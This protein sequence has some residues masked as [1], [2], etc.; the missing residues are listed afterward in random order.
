[1]SE[2][3]GMPRRILGQKK[4]G[5]Y[6]I[7]PRDIVT[8]KVFDKVRH[9]PLRPEFDRTND[10]A[11]FK[12]FH[13]EF[14]GDHS[15]ISG[16]LCAPRRG[17]AYKRPA[18]L[19]CRKGE[20]PVSKCGLTDLHYNHSKINKTKLVSKPKKKPIEQVQKPRAKRDVP[21]KAPTSKMGKKS[22]GRKCFY[23]ENSSLCIDYN[24]LED[25]LSLLAY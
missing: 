5:V 8:P 15:P 25:D 2:D 24:N 1:L 23:N 14:E 12:T 4:E 11:V 18:V 13:M 20:R 3:I 7:N 21:Q 22:I 9:W 6:P 10:A 19:R 16:N 17:Y